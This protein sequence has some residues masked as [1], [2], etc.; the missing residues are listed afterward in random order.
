MEVNVRRTSDKRF[1]NLR[2]DA[3]FQLPPSR[4]AQEDAIEAIK[5]EDTIQDL[6]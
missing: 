5:N 4:K 6:E 1:Q 3:D 2:N